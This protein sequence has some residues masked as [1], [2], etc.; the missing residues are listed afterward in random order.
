MNRLNIETKVRS[1][2]S[3]LLDIKN[4]SIHIPSFQRDYV[5]NKDDIKNLFD[6]IKRK[7]PIGAVLFWSPDNELGGFKDRIGSYYVNSFSKNLTY[8]LDGYQR[9]STLF[10][11]LTNPN[12]TELDRNIEE[13]NEYFNLFY[14]L[15]E[16][17]FV[18]IRPKIEPKPFQIPV[19]LLMNSSD[20]RKYARLN[21]EQIDDESLINK[22]YD[23]ADDLSRTFSDYQIALVDINNA[24]IEE[25]VEIFSRVNSKGQDISYDWMANALSFSDSFSFKDSIDSLLESLQKYNYESIERNL[26]FRCI[27]SSF[28]QLYID[29]TD[30]EYLAKRSDFKEVTK[31]TIPFIERAV[32]FLYEELLVLEPKLIPYNIQLIFIMEFFRKIEEPNKVQ[33]SELKRWFWFTSYS[34]Y[35][36]IYSLSN[37]RRA[38]EYFID[39]LLGKN[40]KAVYLDSKVRFTTATFPEKISLGSVRSKTLLLFLINHSNNF[41]SVDPSQV[42]GY[43]LEQIFPGQQRVISNIIPILVT[44]DTI[45]S[46]RNP[47]KI[48]YLD[49]LLENSLFNLRDNTL[50]KYFIRE[51][52][53]LYNKYDQVNFMREILEDR[54]Y[55]II[56]SEKA[57]VNEIGLDYFEND[58]SDH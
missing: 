33:V 27:Q 43:F 52:Y 9:L 32:K 3:I 54:L 20:F 31:Q 8:I 49:H 21:F 56:Q 2:Q 7:Y 24:T 10:G 47:K 34:N 40:D 28:G 30:I 19:Y 29:N 17:A 14:D 22:Y 15:D 57:F 46:G 41:K 53:K 36:T 6:S 48:N 23:R 51:E 39:F 4:G 1:L 42:F 45:S 37:Q 50:N 38:Y 44:K 58:K 5:W 55:S 12:R 25:A 11:C 35:F 13:W 18:Y 16:D 26:V